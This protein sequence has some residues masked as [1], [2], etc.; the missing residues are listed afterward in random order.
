MGSMTLTLNEAGSSNSIGDPLT[1][2]TPFPDLTVALATAF[3]FFPKHWTSW[4]F[5]S[6]I[7]MVENNLIIIY[8]N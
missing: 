1:L 6:D 5:P 4:P 2:S 8:I 7:I 3:F